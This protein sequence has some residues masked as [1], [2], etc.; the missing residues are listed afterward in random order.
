MGRTD[1]ACAVGPMAI[2]ILRVGVAIGEVI[3]MNIINI[4]I[5]IIIYAG[6]AIFL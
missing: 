1:C 5:L 4:A 3:A 6:D 2:T